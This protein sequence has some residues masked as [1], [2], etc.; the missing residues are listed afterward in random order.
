MQERKKR[1]GD[2]SGV[3]GEMIGEFPVYIPSVSVT[4]I[5]EGGGSVAWVDDQGVLKVGP[6][7][8][9]STPGPACYGRGGTKPT[10]TDALVLLGFLGN[11][12]LGYS[13]VDIQI[14]RSREAITPL[15]DS[16]SMTTEA[17][18]ESIIRIAI[19]G[20]YLE[21][22]K[23]V[24]RQGID[25]RDLS[26]IAFGGAGP[27]LACWLAEELSMKNVVVPLVPGVLSAF[28]GLVADIK[29]DF[30]KITISPPVIF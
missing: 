12:A 8:A 6:E 5:G 26:L 18:A 3:S 30:I 2:A 28:G 17:A 19:S 20:M 1:V 10:I 7:S 4:S 13:A 21:I 9:G 23:L 24:S 11:A 16:L 14:E 15:A 22:S 27:M 29:N 25:P